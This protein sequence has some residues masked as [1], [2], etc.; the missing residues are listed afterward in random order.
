MADIE[1]Q[2]P[3]RQ[4]QFIGIDNRNPET[5]VRAGYVRDMEN[6]VTTRDG[7]MPARRDG[8]A[9]AF[10]TGVRPHSAWGN[11][12]FPWVLFVDAGVLYALDSPDGTPMPLASGL[13]DGLV[14][15]TAVNSDVYW[16]N[17]TQSGMVRPDGEPWPWACEA[18]SGQPQ[19]APSTNGG[20]DAGTYQYAV[21]FRDALGRES[22]TPRAGVVDVPEG[23][24][25]TLT[26]LPQPYDAGVTTLRLYVSEA[27][28]EQLRH[29]HDAAV[30]V[31][32]ITVGKGVLRK[33]LTTQFHEPLPAGHLIASGHGRLFVAR[34]RE[35]Y[36]SESLYYGQG[37]LR[38]NHH[39]FGQQGDRIDALAAVGDGTGG[40]GVYVAC[41]KR[42]YWMA[43]AEPDKWQQVIAYP[44]GA[45]AGTL[46]WASGEVWGLDS[47]APVPSWLAGNGQ[48]CVGL[49]G[50]QIVSYNANTCA[51][52]TADVGAAMVREIDGQRQ[53]VATLRAPRTG[54]GMRDSMT[55]TVRRNGVLLP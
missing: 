41:G 18:P 2:N 42:T 5:K 4:E 29:A 13:S 51:T 25:F 50:G 33:P 38:T 45:V 7:Q 15:Y 47:T 1:T 14:S 30:G 9:E 3:Y 48:F 32:S 39:R 27:N 12:V 53:M 8:Y 37:V 55:T 31:S 28:G 17:G 44:T 16:S 46:C 34:G 24:G 49:P 19:A 35:V 23:G 52:D 43:G 21:T 22:G 20:M 40:A 36:W 11:R 26:G 6:I 54:M 10:Y